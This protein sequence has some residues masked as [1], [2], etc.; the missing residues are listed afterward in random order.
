MLT[1]E[2]LQAPRDVRVRVGAVCTGTL[3]KFELEALAALVVLWHWEHSPGEWTAVTLQQLVEFART[4]P[5]LVDAM[6]NPFW[7]VDL[8]GFI[9]GKWIEGWRCGS[10]TDPGLVTEKFVRSVSNPTCR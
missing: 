2:G 9:E 1:G 4:S 7:H 3:G 6:R 5:P 10:V 8:P